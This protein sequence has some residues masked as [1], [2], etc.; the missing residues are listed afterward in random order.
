MKYLYYK[1]LHPDQYASAL[2]DWYYDI[3]DWKRLDLENPKTYNEKMQW[4]KLYDSIP[5]K[6]R[7]ADKYLVRE[8]VIEKIGE[9][10]LVTLLGVWDNF[11]EI[12]FDKL[13]DK[14][15]LKANH[16]CDWN[17]IV[18][19]KSKFDKEDARRK[20]KSWLGIN[21]AFRNGLELHYLNIPPKIIAEEYLEDINLYDYK[22]MC[23]N[24]EVKFLWVVSD[25]STHRKRRHYLLLSGNVWIKE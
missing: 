6:T 10:Y 4:L 5:M 16:G 24:G 12:D 14:F 9:E 23:F 3:H 19:D 1:G 2:A 25:R 21:F 8:W 20:F 13:P 17:I 7:L 15:A 11:D 22:F 18:T